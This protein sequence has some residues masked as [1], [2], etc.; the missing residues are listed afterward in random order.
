MNS[1]QQDLLWNSPAHRLWSSQWTGVEKALGI[2]FTSFSAISGCFLGVCI[3]SQFLFRF[4]SS[5]MVCVESDLCMPASPAPC[6]KHSQLES[7][8]M[9]LRT[10]LNQILKPPKMGDSTASWVPLPVLDSSLWR[11]SLCQSQFS[12]LQFVA[13]VFCPPLWS[14]SSP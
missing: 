5:R 11:I 13:L 14:L 12:L 6:S 9:L 8:I 3:C 10:L 7:W 4:M 2:Y 1:R